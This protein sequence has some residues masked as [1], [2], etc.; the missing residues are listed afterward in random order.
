MESGTLE[1]DVDDTTKDASGVYLH[2]CTIKSGTL[3]VGTELRAIVDFDRRANIM[4][5][6][7][8]RTFYRP[9]FVKF[10]AIMFIRQVSL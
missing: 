3:E 10:S 2:S 8:A 4:R 5:N 6:H 7:T 1:V 9:H